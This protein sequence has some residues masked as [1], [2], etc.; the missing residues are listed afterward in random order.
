MIDRIYINRQAE[1]RVKA[2]KDEREKRRVQLE[3]MQSGKPFKWDALEEI[4]RLV[5]RARRIGLISEADELLRDPS[6][7]QVG[8]RIF[9]KIIDANNLLDIAYLSEGTRVSRA[10]GRIVLPVTGGNRLGSGFMISPRLLLTNNHVLESE[11]Q[12]S[13]AGIEFDYFAREDGA[14]G[15]VERFSLQPEVLFVTDVALDFSLVAVTPVNDQG[16]EVRDRGWIPLL[17]PSGKAVIGERVSVVQ[18]PNGDP[19]KVVLHDNKVTDI[20]G[21]FLLYRADTMGGSS[22]SPVF[23]I[24]WDLAALHHAA[25]GNA[26]EGIRISSIVTH[27][28]SLQ[29]QENA[30]TASRW[31]L[32][33][34][35]LAVQTSTPNPR[36]R[37]LANVTTRDRAKE[38]GPVVNDDRTAS[39]TIPLSITLGIGN[40]PVIAPQVLTPLPDQAAVPNGTS[41]IDEDLEDAIRAMEAAEGRVY[42][43]QVNDEQDRQVYYPDLDAMADSRL[44]DELSDLIARTHTTT[45]NYKKA[46][47]THLY[48]WIDRRDV[49]N[50][51]LRGIYSNKVFDT[52]EVIRNEIAM[53]RQREA[54]LRKQLEAFGPPEPEFLEELEA[55]HPFN[56]EHVV[57]QSWFNKRKQPKTDLHHLFT[58]EW[59]CN[60]FRSNHAYFDFSQEAYRDNCGENADGKFEPKH[61]KGAVARATLYFLLRYPGEI[62]DSKKEMPIDRLSTLIEWA[63]SDK[64]DRWERHRNAEI[65]KVQGNRNPLIDFPELVAR[66]NFSRGWK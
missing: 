63:K 5:T 43:S 37:I 58:C 48:P 49:K 41:P 1:A 52:L 32:F 47:L 2:R 17:G 66:I 46:R 64:V 60:S 8:N 45:L 22:G 57:P 9:E 30:D 39:W 31:K 50:R 62:S 26:N 35:A 6:N 25:V 11:V 59:G 44:Y 7:M 65:F 4:S 28:K 56:C 14:T 29:S 12:A 21:A 54:A 23:N 36:S 18:H 20:D 15:P 40:A 24:N 13:N 27:L 53:E 3:A 61:G 38:G 42:Y 55:A 19:Q 33:A 10:V 51:E 34:E 16:N